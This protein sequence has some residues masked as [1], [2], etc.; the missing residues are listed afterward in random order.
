MQTS[1]LGRPQ[2]HPCGRWLLTQPGRGGDSACLLPPCTLAPWEETG[3]KT[4]FFWLVTE[5]KVSQRDR[6]HIFF[7]T[8]P[9]SPPWGAESYASGA[10]EGTAWP[11]AAGSLPCRR[12]SGSPRRA[13]TP[14]QVGSP[15]GLAV[16]VSFASSIWQGS[17]AARSATG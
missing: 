6:S 15:E 9:W 1:Q 16:A 4:E 5:R 8:S 17:R 11:S 2:S 7:Q 14:S 3:E 10:R 12:S 13:Q